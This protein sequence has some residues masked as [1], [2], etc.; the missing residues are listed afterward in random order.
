[1][2]VLG[3][4]ELKRPKYF[5]LLMTLKRARIIDVRCVIILHQSTGQKNDWKVTILR[6]RVEKRFLV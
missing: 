2:I 1:M 6:Y 3:G 4:A 5:L